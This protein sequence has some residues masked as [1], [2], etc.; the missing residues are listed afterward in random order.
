MSL[1]SLWNAIKR[2]VR[3]FDPHPRSEH[4]VHN[5]RLSADGL[6]LLVDP[7]TF[8]LA[9][10]LCD[11][12]TPTMGC[13]FN[14]VDHILAKHRKFEW[15]DAAEERMALESRRMRRRNGPPQDH[16]FFGLDKPPFAQP[17]FDE[18]RTR[19]RLGDPDTLPIWK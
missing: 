19:Y 3:L 2:E 10:Y 11:F 14:F 5:A 8:T 4:W 16:C 17:P 13:H 9:S 12:A 7:S 18:L 6:W 15:Y 1:Q